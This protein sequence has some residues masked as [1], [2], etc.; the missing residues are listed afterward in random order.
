M[1]TIVCLKIRMLFTSGLTNFKVEKSLFNFLTPKTGYAEYTQ[2]H[3]ARK[4]KIF[5]L[6]LS[7]T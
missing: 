6:A 1:L 2:K 3:N 5:A 4:Q 7:M